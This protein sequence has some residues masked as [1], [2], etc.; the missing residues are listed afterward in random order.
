MDLGL[1]TGK[2]TVRNLG[3]KLGRSYKEK[4]VGENKGEHKGKPAAK[5]KVGKTWGEQKE[6]HR[7]ENQR[8]QL[9]DKIG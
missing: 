1:K 5:K 4:G 7:G 6:E 8:G 9:G 2:K 3:E